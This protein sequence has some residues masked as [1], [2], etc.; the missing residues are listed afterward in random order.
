MKERKS[1]MVFI[2]ETKCSMD[3]I[4]EIHSKWLSRY[5]YLEVKADNLAGGILTL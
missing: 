5:E 4:R 1:D 3:K 2:Q